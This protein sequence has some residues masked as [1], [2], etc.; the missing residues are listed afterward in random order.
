MTNSF[1]K[2]A[3]NPTISTGR[4]AIETTSDL[5]TQ[6]IEITAKKV[7]GQTIQPER[8]FTTRSRYGTDS[9]KNADGTYSSFNADFTNRGEWAYIKLVTSKKQADGYKS[10][11]TNRYVTP[12]SKDLIGDG[13]TISE[14]IDEPSKTGR[15]YDK[16]LIT[17]ISCQMSEKVQISEVFGDNEV[18]YYFGRQPMIFNISGIL[19]DSPDNDWFVEWLKMY[20]EFLRGSQTARNYELIKIILPNMIIT[21]T[22][23]GFAWNQDS[24]RD[25]DIPF[26]FQFIAKVIEPRPATGVFSKTNKG[27][28]INYDK[29]HDLVSQSDINN[30]KQQASTL[31]NVINDPKSSLRD[32]GAALSKLGT[33]TGGQYGLNLEN[34]KNTLLG[35]KN[36]IDSWTKSENDYF[37]SV[38][39]SALF[40]TVTSS[41]TGIRLN[42]FSPVYGILSSLTKLVS[43]TF[44]SA[45]S[46]FN[47]M[48]L[49]LRAIVRD[50][51]NISNQAIGL[52]NLV[53]S[54]IKGF[55]RNVTGQIRG[56]VR[57]FDIA[58]KTVGKAAGAIATAP[59]TAAQ[60]ASNMFS[61]GTLQSTTPFLSMTP[62]LY[63]TRAAL[64]ITKTNIP[65]KQEMLVNS[66]KYAS[67][68]GNKL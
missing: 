32:K 38:R 59:I 8:L 4:D 30:L 3:N 40:Q 37:N 61:E 60:A 13:S 58:V 63:Y 41:L 50:I 2:A 52:V 34:T 57:D 9:F 54:S 66:P 68:S 36:T 12:G 51:I 25:V 27:K 47:S 67:K 24:S 14:M 33:G 29:A 15:G 6:K 44:N 5:A 20:S 22:I 43:N 16:F 31:T 7:T 45:T 42:L 11:S 1:I 26:N 53:N 65:S 35:V 23:S 62:K 55:G 18:V 10:G 64:S 21:G 28:V 48:I 19:V 56:L 17:N 49:P 39:N 46:I